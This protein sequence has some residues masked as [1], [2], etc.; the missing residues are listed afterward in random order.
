MPSIIIILYFKFYLK[1]LLERIIGWLE[2]MK[3][4][5]EELYS[6][7][8]NEDADGKLDHLR[9]SLLEALQFQMDAG[10]QQQV[11]KPN[12]FPKF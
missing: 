10:D 12:L 8:N 6:A 7:S 2:S 4:N 3:V 9:V 11:R 1:I 5:V